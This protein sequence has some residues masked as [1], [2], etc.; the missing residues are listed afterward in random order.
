MG[1]GHPTCRGLHPPRCPQGKGPAAQGR[2]PRDAQGER[3]GG[4]CLC[5]VFTPTPLFSYSIPPP[6]RGRCLRAK[7][8]QVWCRRQAL[9]PA[10]CHPQLRNSSP[11]T[12]G[13]S[14]GI[15]VSSDLWVSPRSGGGGNRGGSGHWVNPARLGW[16]RG[17][18]GDHWWEGGD[19]HRV[20]PGPPMFLGT[21]GGDAATWG[22]CWVVGS[23]PR[24]QTEPSPRGQILDSSRA[25]PTLCG[26]KPVGSTPGAPYGAGAGASTPPASP[27]AATH[28]LPPLPLPPC[29]RCRHCP[30]RWE[31]PLAAG[32]AP[33]PGECPAGWVPPLPPL[34][35]AMG[36]PCCG[37]QWPWDCW[38]H[39]HPSVR[40]GA[41][42]KTAP[43]STAPTALPD[44][45]GKASTVSS[46]SPPKPSPPPRVPT[47]DPVCPP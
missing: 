16:G 33:R 27:P 15:G 34:P 26:P 5:Q 44:P 30:R 24:T 6:A 32:A 45:V 18:A 41:K 22:P 8:N 21:H 17:P 38:T 7:S 1:W 40:P 2:Y 19:G 14:T 3:G 39:R 42:P 28:G 47:P 35:P 12:R 4:S 10:L 31:T 37:A 9:T 29:R 20:G 11:G 13:N 46:R 36:E 25:L 23:G 43:T